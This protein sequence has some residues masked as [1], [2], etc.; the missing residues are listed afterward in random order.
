MPGRR[1]DAGRDPNAASHRALHVAGERFDV[2]EERGRDYLP[3]GV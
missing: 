2:L 1:A 3:G